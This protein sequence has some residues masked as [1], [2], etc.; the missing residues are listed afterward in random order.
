MNLGGSGVLPDDVDESEARARIALSL[1]P[2][3]ALRGRMPT[4]G[5]PELTAAER[6]DALADEDVT[7]AVDAQLRIARLRGAELAI[8]G[9]VR[10]PTQIDALGVAAPWLLWC[11]GQAVLRSALLE[12]VAVVG[13]RSATGYGVRISADWSAELASAG[14]C[15]VSGGAFGID[16]AAHRGALSSG[17]VTILVSAGGLDQAYP[18]AHEELYRRVQAN[19]AVVS[20]RLFGVP[21]RRPYFLERNGLIA[22]MTRG[23]VVVEAAERSGALSTARSAAGLGRVVMS[24][25]GQVTSLMS[26]GTNRLISDGVAALVAS[27]N[28]VLELLSP[29][30]AATTGPEARSA[31]PRDGLSAEVRG[32]LERLPARRPLT[33]DEIAQCVGRPPSEVAGHLADLLAGG[34]VDVDG[35]RGARRYRLTARARSPT[36]R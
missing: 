1:W 5:S 16:A 35:A 32:V 30:G 9:S 8:P 14:K 13:A 28:D 12:S 25:P 20:S 19:G 31:D 26:R 4:A 3:P 10:W 22:A 36:V 17:G 2:R 11:S 33:L 7:R 6:A 29:I 34:W 15:V 24:V 18:R 23:T 27:A 21:P